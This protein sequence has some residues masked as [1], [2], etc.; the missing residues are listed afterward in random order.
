MITPAKVK[1]IE[2]LLHAGR[3]SQRRIARV[4]GISRAT[5]GAI[6]AGKRPDY[7]ERRQ[8]RRLELEELPLGPP[9]R[10]AGCG[11]LVYMPCRLCRVRKIKAQE[12]AALSF[13]RKRKREAALERLVA[14]LRRCADQTAA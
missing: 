14:V 8:L 6:A 4:T 9:E 5:V 12:Q 1:E 7:E 2:I 10:C 13:Y 11:G 3:L